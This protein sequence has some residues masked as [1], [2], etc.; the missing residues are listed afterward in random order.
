MM[1]YCVLSIPNSER[2]VCP[3]AISQ[4]ALSA[5]LDTYALHFNY[6]L[7]CMTSLLSI[8]NWIVEA[9]LENCT[10]VGGFYDKKCF[11]VYTVT[12]LYPIC[13]WATLRGWGVYNFVYT[14]IFTTWMKCSVLEVATLYDFFFLLP[15]QAV[16]I[17]KAH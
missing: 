2:T 9:C 3:P 7:A 6:H 13:A 14:D 16:E 10:F 8:E 1:C 12:V 17:Q 15:D 5:A 4:A 11:F